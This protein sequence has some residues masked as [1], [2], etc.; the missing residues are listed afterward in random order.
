[1]SSMLLNP[2]TGFGAGGG[3]PSFA[4]VVLLLPCDGTNGSTTI[5][6]LSNSG[7]T[8]VAANGAALSTVQKKFGTASLEF[9]GV[10]DYV[11]TTV[12]PGVGS[13]PF[14]MEAHV[15]CAAAQTGRVVSAQSLSTPNAVIAFRVD[16]NGAITFILRNNGGTGTVVLSTAAGA[17]TTDNS[18]WQ[19]VAVTR[20]GSNRIDI[21]VDGVSQANTTSSTSPAGAPSYELGSQNAG[22]EFYCG[23]VDNVRITEGVCR[24]NST[25]TPPT[26]AYPTS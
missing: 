15:R 26:A 24:Y 23:F 20:D 3:D 21:W 13:G 2:F 22:G 14:T 7:S 4:S 9:D 19:H 12:T 16:A 6:D 18:A 17:V 1:M 5:P 10:N 8:Q 25:F 11:T